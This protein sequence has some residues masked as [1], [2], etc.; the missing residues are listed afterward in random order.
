MN[1]PR[2]LSTRRGSLSAS[3]PWAKN[4]IENDTETSS[5]LSI[6]RVGAAPAIQLKPPPP[7]R[8]SFASSFSKERATSPRRASPSVPHA[9]TPDELM[10]LARPNTITS[11][12]RDPTFTPLPDDIL[13]PFIDRPSEVGSLISSAP[14]ARLFALLQLT[15]NASSHAGSEDP[16]KWSYAQLIDW[17]TKTNRDTV[18]DTLW[19]ANTRRCIMAHSETIWERVKGAL[20]VPCELDVDAPPSDDEQN[21]SD[22]EDSGMKARGH[23]ADWDA[24]MDSPVFDKSPPS[25]PLI[26]EPILS[27]PSTSPF[28]SPTSANNGLNGIMEEEETSAPGTATANT[29]EEEGILPSQI[30]G[31]RISTSLTPSSPAPSP[32]LTRPGMETRRP[33]FGSSPMRSSPSYS[34]F[35]T[36]RRSR[37]ASISSF[38]SLSLGPLATSV[39]ERSSPLFPSSFAALKP[40]TMVK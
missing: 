1:P 19:V 18:P 23:W 10:A 32:T 3:D 37:P 25:S 34:P 24:V 30:H 36:G 12:L 26:I 17:L 35:L 33:S 14:S 13:L 39:E 7:A 20:G 21:T 22:L 2:R 15:F 9:V 31:I 29:P 40:K 8:L 6:M 4:T 28:F 16:A 11:P 27:S 38:S 5:R